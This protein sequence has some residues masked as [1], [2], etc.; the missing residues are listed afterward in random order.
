MDPPQRREA[1]T[2]TAEHPRPPRGGS[3]EAA[4]DGLVTEQAAKIKTCDATLGQLDEILTGLAAHR[5]SAPGALRVRRLVESLRDGLVHE[6]PV[7]AAEQALDE[8][9]AADGWRHP[10]QALET[11]F[12]DWGLLL[13]VCDGRMEGTEGTAR[14]Q[15]EGVRR[16]L[17]R[18][19]P[20]LRESP[21]RWTWAPTGMAGESR[22]VSFYAQFIPDSP[23]ESPFAL[24][25]EHPCFFLY[26]CLPRAEIVP[27]R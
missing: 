9:L 2:P 27:F 11:P 5:E 17:L 19:Y 20:P 8:L 22:D 21:K 23:S 13:R 4:N 25:E 26:P 15:L 18:A 1:P 16:K 7:L 12:Q 14:S 3:A 10:S 24:K 6:F